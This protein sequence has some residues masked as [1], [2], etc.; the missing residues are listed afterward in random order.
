MKLKNA[1]ISILINEE[2]TTIEL[3]DDDSGIQFAVVKLTATQLAQ[4]LSRLKYTECECELHRI[5]NVGKKLETDQIVFV[6]PNYAYEDRKNA[7]TKEAAKR[8]P[9]GWELYD[10]FSSQSTFYEYKGVNYVR[11]TI[12]RW[13]DKKEGEPKDE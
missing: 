8:M 9:Y 4:A 10:N 6:A 13:V 7:L 11:A 5:E 1:R 12:R 3:K 2:F